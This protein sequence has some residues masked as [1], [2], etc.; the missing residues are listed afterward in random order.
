MMKTLCYSVVIVA[1]SIAGVD[2][3]VDQNLLLVFLTSGGCLSMGYIL[4]TDVRTARAY[5]GLNLVVGEV[6][7][8][9]LGLKKSVRPNKKKEV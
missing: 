4:L 8:S 2:A 5:E 7:R 3:A 9:I 6:N 1:L